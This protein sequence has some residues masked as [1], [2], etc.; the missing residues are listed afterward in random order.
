MSKDCNHTPHHTKLASY[1]NF[2]WCIGNNYAHTTFNQ[3]LTLN[4]DLKKV[5]VGGM[6]STSLLHTPLCYS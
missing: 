3:Q 5:N 6:Q 1:S 4:H 2:N